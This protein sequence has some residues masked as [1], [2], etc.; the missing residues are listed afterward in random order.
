[1]ATSIVHNPANEL[2][3][4][5]FNVTAGTNVSIVLNASFRAG[6]VCFLSVRF[7]SANALA[8]GTT[9]FTVPSGYRPATPVGYMAISTYPSL[10]S[11]ALGTDGKMV[12]GTNFQAN[13][14]YRCMIQYR[15]A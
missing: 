13:A 15:I 4:V 1:M 7:K 3:P 8:N 10:L 14:E 12:I 11:I 5:A 9:V 6:K 2:T